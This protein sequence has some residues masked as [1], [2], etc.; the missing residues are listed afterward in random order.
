[1]M[2]DTQDH[3]SSWD[4]VPAPDGDEH[5]PEITDEALDREP[6]LPQGFLEWFVVS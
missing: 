5:D 4:E 1:M 6:L 2:Y 3:V